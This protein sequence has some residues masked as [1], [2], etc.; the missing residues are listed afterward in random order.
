MKK[1]LATTALSLV[2]GMSMFAPNASA[3][4]NDRRH[5]DREQFIQS[6]CGR[7]GDSDCRDWRQ[8]RHHWDDAQYHGWYQRHR[9]EHD[10]R[11]DET[12]A[13]IFGFTAGGVARAVNDVSDESHAAACDARYRSYDESSDTFMGYD[14]FR[15]PCM[16]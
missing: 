3:R 12:A 8:N 16:L 15:H 5:G 7:H 1:Y 6:Y 4:D 11:G 2:L 14:G 9:H 10:F 13:M